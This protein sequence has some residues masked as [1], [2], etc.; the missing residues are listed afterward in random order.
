MS[1]FKEN[2]GREVD[3]SEDMDDL[4]ES[5]PFASYDREKEQ[6]QIRLME[7]SEFNK[8]KD[9]LAQGVSGVGAL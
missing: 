7:E 9:L 1:E 5:N 6:E 2:Y 4:A 3:Y 8:G